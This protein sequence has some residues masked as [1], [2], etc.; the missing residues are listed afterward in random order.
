MTGYAFADTEAAAARL[1]VVADVFNPTSR[2]FLE[3]FAGR[4]VG[5]ALDLGCGTGHT[6][7]LLTEALRPRLAVGLDT[8]EAFLRLARARAS[9]G[10]SFLQHDVTTV[11]FP[12]GPADVVYC[13]FL[14]S[15]LQQPQR[16]LRAWATQLREHGLLLIEEVETIESS[17]PV[18][19]R[20]LEIVRS[21]LAERGHALEVGPVVDA[22]QNPASLR[23]LDSRVVAVEPRSDRAAR[24]FLMNLEVW[25]A[26]DFV[27]ATYA[28]DEIDALAAGLADLAGE[29]RRGEI[30][31]ALRQL[32]FRASG[33]ER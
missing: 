14:L 15:H 17:H 18:F 29:R 16:L 23:K 25:R 32:T 8:S 30:R 11:P 31:W 28:D 20:Y 2:A 19:R 13:R 9:D 27:R 7:R 12:A 21:M 1:A 4:A 10:I 5:L 26:D 3:R 24:M 33:D 22:V 6:T